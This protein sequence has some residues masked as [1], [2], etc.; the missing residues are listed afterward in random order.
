[1]GERMRQ[2]GANCNQDGGW[3]G[4]RQNVWDLVLGWDGVG[5]RGRGRG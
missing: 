2:R 1:M 5:I 3:Y 4:V